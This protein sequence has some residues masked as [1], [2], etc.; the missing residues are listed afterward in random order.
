MPPE[1]GGFTWLKAWKPNLVSA[2]DKSKAKAKAFVKTLQ[3]NGGTFTLNALKAAFR[4]KGADTLV[5]LSDGMPNDFDPKLN[6]P[7]PPSKILDDL[8]A[9]NRARR[10]VINTF[11]FGSGGGQGGARRLHAEVGRAEQRRLHQDSMR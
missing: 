9:L 5:L 8:S 6:Q 10:L 3:A 11:G 7:Q 4:I 2:T 1:M